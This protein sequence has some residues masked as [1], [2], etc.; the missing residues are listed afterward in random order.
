MPPKFV[1]VAVAPPKDGATFH[2]IV[3]VAEDGSIWKAQVAG[4]ADEVR[5]GWVRLSTPEE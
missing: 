1:Q 4:H 2:V 5:D 3:A